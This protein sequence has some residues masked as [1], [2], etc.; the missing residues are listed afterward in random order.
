MTLPSDVDAAFNQGS[1]HG[2]M[3]M[4]MGQWRALAQL[5]ELVRYWWQLPEETRSACPR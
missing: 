1:W 3:G 4:N 5:V 2:G